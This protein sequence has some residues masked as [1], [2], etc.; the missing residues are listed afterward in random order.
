VAASA[1]LGEPGDTTMSSAT[2]EFT[3]DHDEP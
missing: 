1:M 2:N 3:S